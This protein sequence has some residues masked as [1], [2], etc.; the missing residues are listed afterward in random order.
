MLHKD[1]L[2]HQVSF[3]LVIIWNDSVNNNDCTEA[4]ELTVVSLSLYNLRD[5]F[6]QSW[7]CEWLLKDGYASWFVF[8]MEYV[9][10]GNCIHTALDFLC[11]S[12][13][14]WDDDCYAS[15]DS[16]SR[17]LFFQSILLALLLL[18]PSKECNNFVKA[19]FFS[20][21]LHI[22]AMLYAIY[23]IGI[24]CLSAKD[25]GW[26]HLIPSSFILRGGNEAAGT[27]LKEKWER[28]YPLAAISCH[29]TPINTSVVFH[30]HHFDMCPWVRS[31]LEEFITLAETHIKTWLSCSWTKYRTWRGGVTSYDTEE[32]ENKSTAENIT[33][34]LVEC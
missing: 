21:T 18:F 28:A 23:C 9:R 25:L 10:S 27:D 20:E 32:K 34:G 8:S 16:Q 4:I 26:R 24:R 13:L 12:G 22:T 30:F 2:Q 29:W 1:I 33:S 7:F 31:I 5:C 6:I 17:R 19:S 14:G 15:L 3:I 11:G